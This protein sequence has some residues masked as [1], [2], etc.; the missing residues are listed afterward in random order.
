MNDDDYAILVGIDKYPKF[1]NGYTPAHLQGPLN[2]VNALKRWLTDPKG[3]AVPPANVIEISPAKREKYEPHQPNFS[4]INMLFDELH[5]RSSASGK[6]QF[7]RRVYIYMSGHGFSP[8]RSKA[9]IYTADARQ[10]NGQNVH[11]T[12]WLHWLQ[13]SGYFREFV[14]WIDACMD[15]DYS[16]PPGEPSLKKITVNA[17]PL[18]NFVAFA[19]QRP[20]K[21]LE[22]PI[23]EDQGKFHGAFTWALLEGLR[24]SAADANGRVTGRSLGDWMRNAMAAR[25]TD[26][27]RRDANISKEPEILEEDA[28]LIFVRGAVAPDIDV[29]LRFPESALGGQARIW[30]GSPPAIATRFALKTSSKQLRLRAGLYVAEVA[31]AGIRHGFEVLQPSVVDIRDEGAA[32]IET[33]PKML[34]LEIDPHNPAAEIFVIDSRFSLADFGTGCLS[35]QL[36]AGLFKIKIRIA[37]AVTEE[38]VLLDHSRAA[39]EASSEV[40][41][42]ATVIPLS[43]TAATHETHQYARERAVAAA[44]ALPLPGGAASLM[45]LVRTFSSRTEPVD[46]TTPPWQ[47]VQLVDGAGAVVLDMDAGEGIER[48]DGPDGAAFAAVTVAPGCYYLR[49]R[50]GVAGAQ[51]ATGAPGGDIGSYPIEQSIIACAGWRTEVY[52]LRRVIPEASDIDGRPR[53]SIAMR[54]HATP[55]TPATQAEDQVAEAARLALA[56]ERRVLNRQLERMLMQEF[57]NPVAAIIGGHLLLIDQERDPGRDMSMLPEVVT[58]LRTLLGL[59]H[60]DVEALASCCAG[61]APASVIAGPPMFQRSWALLARAACK[62]RGLIPAAMWKRVHA[63]TLLPPFLVWNT[64][65]QVKAAA[66]QQLEKMLLEAAS[67]APEPVAPAAASFLRRASDHRPV[68]ASMMAGM[69]GAAAMAPPGPG[70]DPALLARAAAMNLPPSALDVLSHAR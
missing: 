41:V 17:P 47:G 7:G 36:P 37:H 66:Q 46:H 30:S 10:D 5:T 67:P 68:V 32:V 19:A 45:I 24:G 31:S 1:G 15:R 16:Y 52:V 4:D 43:G 6:S 39:S 44:L 13:D 42:P 64:D 35:T 56:S 59:A 65:Q 26:R 58:H 8:S 61:M 62:D 51:L 22:V 11:A 57:D 55:M 28:S 69:R 14:L 21:A 40:A 54:R 20:W 29:T 23:E 60:P 48:M 9:C 34:G 38:V 63:E 70:V 3:G 18:A 53:V 33:P 12:G 27:D 49:Q 2:D 50:R 25:F